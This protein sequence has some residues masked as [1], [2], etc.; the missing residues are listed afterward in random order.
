MATFG[1]DYTRSV[2]ETRREEQETDIP[3][4]NGYTLLGWPEFQVGK[5][6][7]IFASLFAAPVRWQDGLWDT[8]VY[9]N[10]LEANKLYRAQVDLYYRLFDDHPDE[11]QLILD[12]ADLQAVLNAWED[13]TAESDRKSAT[14]TI[15]S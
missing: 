11:F 13:E 5:V 9:R 12:R 10:V 3:T 15:R 1:R 8:Q 14:Y 4:Q 7:V 6:A 2:H